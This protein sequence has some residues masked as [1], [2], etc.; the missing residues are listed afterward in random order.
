MTKREWRQEMKKRLGRMTAVGR[1]HA[2]VRV[3]KKLYRISAFQDASTVLFYAALRDEVDTFPA[4]RRALKLGKRVALPCIG[5][6]KG[7][8]FI[9][10]IHDLKRDLVKGPFGIMEPGEKLPRMR[11]SQLDLVLCPALA[12]DLGGTRLGRGG[13]YYDRFL[14]SLKRGTKVVGL[15]FRCQRVARL[16][17]KPHD[18]RVHEIIAG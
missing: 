9:R 5:T 6:A 12:F 2:S 16:P 8:M 18:A 3:L 13:G 14:K 4:I 15:A 17:R 11:K 1:R 7:R 10:E